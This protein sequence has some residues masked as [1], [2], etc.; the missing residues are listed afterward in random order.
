MKLSGTM[1]Y[2][3]AGAIAAAGCAASLFAGPAAA[4]EKTPPGWIADPKTGCKVWNASP[5]SNE[6]IKWSGGC[7]NGLADGHG[8]LQ[9]YV[10]G[11]P[12]GE[13]TEG[14]FRYGR[15]N[16]R[17]EIRW[18]DGRHYEGQ[19]RNNKADGL[20]KK[21]QANGDAYEGEFLDDQKHGQGIA[22]W[23]N[24]DSYEGQWRLNAADGEGTYVWS[25]GE[26][27]SGSWLAG[28]PHGQGAF[29]ST[30]WMDADDPELGEEMSGEW[31]YGCLNWQGRKVAVLT[32]WAECGLSE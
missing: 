25:N 19:V 12:T 27:Y 22:T 15:P 24:G 1:R 26:R 18:P 23:R 14:E 10:N 31:V 4:Q 2:A 28:K 9:W 17:V 20:G 21:T 6:T 32:T 5:A 3:L 11:S 8:K 30:R 29:K 16:G 7:R 13:M